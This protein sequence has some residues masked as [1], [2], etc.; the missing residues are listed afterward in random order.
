MSVRFKL[1][2]SDEPYR[3]ID[4]ENNN[5]TVGTYRTIKG[6]IKFANDLNTGK[7]YLQGVV[8]K[9]NLK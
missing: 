9:R 6:A 3:V 1:V 8:G 4:T 7:R 5:E 2:C